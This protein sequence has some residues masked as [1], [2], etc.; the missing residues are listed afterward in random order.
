M[1]SGTAVATDVDAAL[2]EYSV[3]KKVVS[4]PISPHHPFYMLGLKC[5]K[6][7][8]TRLKNNENDC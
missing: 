2:F 3:R 1:N 6:L 8:H 5:V 4:T 7:E